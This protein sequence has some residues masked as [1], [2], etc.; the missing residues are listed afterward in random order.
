ML[1]C[2]AKQ[3]EPTSLLLVLLKEHD[4]SFKFCRRER[5]FLLEF[6]DQYSANML[7]EICG[8]ELFKL[9]HSVMACMLAL[10][11]MAEVS[12]NNSSQRHAISEVTY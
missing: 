10:L 8:T 5:A 2:N 4:S 6:L 3:W 1:V 11:A 9:V 7:K 12:L